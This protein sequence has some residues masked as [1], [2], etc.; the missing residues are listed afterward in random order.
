LPLVASYPHD[1]S[2]H[3]HKHQ[4]QDHYSFYQ[5]TQEQPRYQHQ[6]AM[7][8]QPQSSQKKLLMANQQIYEALSRDDAA[9]LSDK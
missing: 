2:Y 5:P 9:L 8:K 4:Q 1:N 7:E 3:H 6:I